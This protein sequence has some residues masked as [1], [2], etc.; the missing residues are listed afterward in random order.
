MKR[1][2]YKNRTGQ[3]R[4]SL[5]AILGICLG[6][7]ILI[8]LVTGLILN[9]TL[10]EETYYRL[11]T[12]PRAKADD[13]ILFVSDIPDVVA[14]PYA[15]GDD[16]AEAT[17]HSAVAVSLNT[18]EGDYRY[19]SEVLSYF[20]L[21]DPKKPR[22]STA[23]ATLSE[24][25]VYL[26][27]AF[28]L[29][30]QNEL[31]PT[32]RYAKEAEESALLRE[33]FFLGGDDLT[34]CGLDLS[35]A[36]ENSLAYLKTLKLAVGENA[37]G[38]AVPYELLSEDDGR[39]VLEKLT[40]VCDFLVLDLREVEKTTPLDEL[41]AANDFAHTQYQMRLLFDAS[42]TSFIADAQKQGVASYEI[43]K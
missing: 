1:S 15:F 32:R 6:A 28:Y 34:L 20:N 22:S 36:L 18:P 8:A 14:Y 19:Y 29:R 21:A 26:C 2:R 17:G 40:A 43:L 5:L 38:V 11:T 27:G 30:A 4:L 31:D 39:Q 33:F 42:Q 3:R 24:Y 13:T 7:A 35:G 9:K 23:F 37:L 41:L 16:L 25:R 12:K 10:D